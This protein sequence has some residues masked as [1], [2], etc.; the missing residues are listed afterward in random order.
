MIC[1]LFRNRLS[2]GPDELL[3][4]ELEF[5]PCAPKENTCRKR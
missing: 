2:A 4:D 3:P 1:T 5:R